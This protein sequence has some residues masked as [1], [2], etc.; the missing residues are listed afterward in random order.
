MLERELG[1]NLLAGEGWQALAAIGGTRVLLMLLWAGLVREDP[2]LKIEQVG[3]MLN[4]G[5]MNEV[6]AAVV[7][8]VNRF[9]STALAAVEPASRRIN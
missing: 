8:E 6:G 2:A 3:A 7:N 9:R 5:N 4:L 1:L